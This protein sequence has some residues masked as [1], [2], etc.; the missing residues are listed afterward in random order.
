MDKRL[1]Y[2][3]VLK[4]LFVLSL[5]LLTFVFINSLF[6]QSNDENPGKTSLS[7]V[8]LDISG[9]V[10]GD[11]R[12]TQWKGKQVNVLR[13]DD[14]YFTYINVGD[15]GNCPLFKEPNGLKDIC[16]G[17]HFDYSGREKSNKKHG[18][19][20]FSPPSYYEDGILYIGVSEK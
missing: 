8:K 15:S 17:T 9:M 16:T 7:I 5:V 10:K 1:I 18:F 20:L 12:K 4:L 2:R 19:T 11:I 14:K 13:I 6:V 3:V